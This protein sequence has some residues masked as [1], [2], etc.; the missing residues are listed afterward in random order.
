VAIVTFTIRRDGSVT[1]L[2][3]AQSSGNYALDTSAQRA[4]LEAAPLPPLPPQFE[5]DSAAV[6][7]WFEL[8]R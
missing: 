8:K 7:F 6:E 2:R 4:I 1:G 3:L 5:R